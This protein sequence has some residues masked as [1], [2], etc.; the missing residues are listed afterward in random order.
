[1]VKEQPLVALLG[2]SGSGKSSLVFAGLLPKLRKEGWI[3]ADFRPGDDP[4]RAM[5]TALLPLYDPDLSKTDRLIEDK[6]LSRSLQKTLSKMMLD[7]LAVFYTNE[8]PIPNPNRTTPY[9]DIDGVLME[10]YL[11][12]PSL[13]MKLTA[14]AVYN[15]KIAASGFVKSSGYKEVSRA[16]LETVLYKLMEPE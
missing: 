14:N 10:F 3:I 1:M 7:T 16:Y 12:L 6:K 2:A 9:H 8:I 13:K 5:A 15:K 11:Q 4:F